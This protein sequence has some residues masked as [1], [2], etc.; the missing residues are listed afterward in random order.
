MTASRCVVLGYGADTL[1]TRF[2]AILLAVRLTRA[3]G[4]HDLPYFKSH[5]AHYNRDVG[6]P[7]RPFP[8][9]APRDGWRWV[10]RERVG[11]IQGISL[12]E[13]PIL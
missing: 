9:H 3:I 5:G 10:Y 7:I 11:R 1:A 6:T 4:A 13:T 2:S 12:S 8:Y